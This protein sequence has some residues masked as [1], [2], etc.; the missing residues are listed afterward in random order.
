MTH[1]AQDG[2]DTVNAH[3]SR[4]ERTF[5]VGKLDVLLRT[6]TRRT[7]DVGITARGQVVVRAPHGTTTMEAA[8]LV[9]RRREWIYLQLLRLERSRAAPIT[10]VLA[11]GE[12]FHVFGTP[13][14]LHLADITDAEQPVTTHHD[15]ETGPRLHLD[16]RL[17]NR[18]DH[19]RHTLI[20]WYAQQAQNWLDENGGQLVWNPGKNTTRL[21]ASVRLSTA[22]IAHRPRHELIL[23]WAA[24]QL[25]D[26]NLRVLVADTLGRAPAD[27]LHR[28]HG[29]YRIVWLGDV[30]TPA[31]SCAVPHNAT[32]ANEVSAPTSK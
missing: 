4:T 21:R 30:R 25:T 28:L 29:T 3:V 32:S 19:A 27:A 24:A 17:A 22:L 9:R 7:K 23:S 13:H 2:E 5:K 15:P 1:P 10:K 16:R 6:S 8:N 20:H 12:E 14:R 18:P 26:A 11:E 31:T